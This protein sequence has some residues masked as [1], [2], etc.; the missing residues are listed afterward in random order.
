M[1][2]VWREV[3]SF[4]RRVR[5]L[6]LNQFTIKLGFNMLM[7]YLAGHL[8][9]G[10][11]LAA[12]AVGL[13]LGM[14]NAGQRGLCLV[15][16][17]LADRCGCKRAIVAGCALRTVGFA[18]LGVATNLPMLIVGAVV[19]GFAG[20]L[21]DPGARTYLAAAAGPR[22]AEAF[23]LLNVVGQ[24]G[25][26]LGPLLGLALLRIDFRAVSAAAAGTFLLLTVVQA[27]ALPGRPEPPRRAGGASR[28]V[29]RNG[30]FWAFSVV[31][32]GAY[33]LS[34]QIYLALP[35][36]MHRALGDEDTIGMGEMFALSAAV[37]I[38]GQSRITAF[39]RR[40]MSP[41]RTLVA[42]LAV[43]AAA[44]LPLVADA[45]PHPAAIGPEELGEILGIAP[46]LV[47]AALLSTGMALIC[48]YEMDGIIA[49]ARGR[50]VATHYGLY[51]TVSGVGITAG[52]M[53]TGTVWDG[54]ARAGLT[55]LPW[56][57]LAGTGAGCAITLAAL[58]RSG[59]LAPPGPGRKVR[60]RLTPR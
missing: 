57:G 52:S 24:L 56:A 53:L 54:A 23:A 27:R 36:A 26:L 37:V 32:S 43:M 33:V 30:R 15:G 20:A 13:V 17:G 6:L 1:I 45:T 55:W 29:L 28:T 25:L 14:R 10:L 22:R 34:F 11:G 47:T 40:R 19:T 41:A 39:A 59:R 8:A 49:L 4:D 2:G 35:L 46:I 31:M 16:G 9:H 7:P 38:F 44:F 42:G 12:W 5:L 3:R 51:S 60:G 48:P 21:F 50:L 58:D 18:L